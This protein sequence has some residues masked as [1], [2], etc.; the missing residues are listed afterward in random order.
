M[1]EVVTF[2]MFLNGKE[3]LMNI[4]N[5]MQQANAIKITMCNEIRGL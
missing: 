4:R 3:Y 2:L 1:G 5:K